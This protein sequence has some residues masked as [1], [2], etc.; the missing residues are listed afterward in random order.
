ML[1]VNG[2]IAPRA[3]LPEA[4]RFT[5]RTGF[6]VPWMSTTGGGWQRKPTAEELTTLV[7]KPGDLGSWLDVDDAELTV[8]HSWD[9]SLVRLRAH[10]P[11]THTLG[12]AT[13]AG[14][15]PRSFGVREYV[16]WNVRQGMK[17]PGQWYLNRKAG[18]LVYWPL[19]G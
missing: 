10:D 8:Y 6:K 15:P 13:P 1:V 16:V 14:H 11:A 7:Y 12:F 18:K 17:H 2:R 4:G 3:G 19:P 9:E 5:H